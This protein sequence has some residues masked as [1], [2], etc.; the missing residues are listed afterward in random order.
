MKGRALIVD[1]DTSI[2]EVLELRL[3]SLGLDV[4]AA[5]TTSQAL[6]A[7]DQRRYDVA[8]IDLWMDPL[9]GITLMERMHQAQPRLPILIMSGQATIE[10][11]VSAVQRGAF[12]FLTKPFVKGELQG[13]VARALSHRRWARDR[14]RLRTVGETLASSGVLTRVL[15]AVAQAAVETTEAEHS[16]VF[17]LEKGKLTP[18]ARAGSPAAASQ[19]M[20]AA[21]VAAMNKGA[22]VTMPPAKG[23]VA[24]AAP[25]FLDGGPAG[26]LVTEG[27]ERIEPTEDDL[28]LLALFSAQAAVAIRNTHELARL[29][30]GALAALGRIATQVAHELKNP[31][32]G[33]KLY[34]R[35]LEQ[36]LER[37]GDGEGQEIAVKIAGAID[38]L[39]ELVTEITAFGRTP[40]LRRSPTDINALLDDCL[41]LAQD[42]LA[43]GEIQVLREY[44]DTCP[45]AALDAR[46]LR[47]VFLN[48]ILNGLD[49]IESTGVLRVGT[50]CSA[51]VIEVIVEDTGIGM[52]Q[53]TVSRMFDLFFTTKPTGT[54]LGTAIARSVVSQHGGTIHVDSA[55]GA[56]TRVSVRLPATTAT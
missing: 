2:L 40:E 4:T 13:K 52:S 9:D 55:P 25:L 27:S 18:M 56:G 39:T 8:L 41:A 54:G 30:S 1:D 53:E 31:L 35:H 5:K 17:L 15:D 7:V 20:Q 21:A 45:A 42:R 32:G 22:P 43:D 28:E 47:K 50:S 3:A 44:D 12:D 19:T 37:T 23:H 49:A 24:L 46:E 16:V 26:A 48:L 29:R 6:V 10:T 51:D 38:H 34:A 36:R 14:E 11:A 33:L